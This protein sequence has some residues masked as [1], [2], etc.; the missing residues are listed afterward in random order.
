HGL[1]AQLDRRFAAGFSLTAS[2][3][4]SHSIDNLPEQFG[5]G[6]GGLMDTRNFA[7]SRGNSNF[8]TRQR[9]VSSSVWEIPV[10]KGRH[11][12]NRG[13]VLNAIAGGWEITGLLSTQ[14]GHYFTV[15]V[16]NARQRLGSTSI[17]TWWP[18]RIA[19]GHLDRPTAQ[20]WFDTSAFVLPRG[21]DGSWHIGNAGRDI[22]RGDNPF[23]LDAGLSKSFR[24]TERFA[25][26]FRAEAF[27]L[28]NTPTL[29]DPVVN[30]E[31]PDFGTVRST[32]SNAR[33]LQFALRLTF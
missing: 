32:I 14:T 24:I 1:D 18:D 33:Q 23:N 3:T 22:L 12:L 28:T 30:I 17:A 10:G 5:A 16:P 6:G 15:T 19:S 31:S 27:N 9:F 29:D 25:L 26:Q 2:Y 4:W 21:A 20:R 8:D 7:S 13:G 11:W